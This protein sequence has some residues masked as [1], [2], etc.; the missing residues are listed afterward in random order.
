MP[1][2]TGR[3]G[4]PKPGK[5]ART[6]KTAII[7]IILACLLV[8][9]VMYW[10][11]GR[12]PGAPPGDETSGTSREAGEKGNEGN[13]PADMATHLW[14]EKAHL[15]FESDGNKDMLR[16]I[17]DKAGGE[18]SDKTGYRYQWTIN[19]KPSGGDSDS[20][21]DFKRGDIIAVRITPFEEEKTGTAKVM[22]VVVQ[23]TSP[24]VSETKELKNDG[25]NLVYQVIAKDN[26]GDKLTYTLVDAPEGAVID[27]S[28]GVINWSIKDGDKTEPKSFK[29][30][31]S[32]GNGGETVYPVNILVEKKTEKEQ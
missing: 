23:N 28:S 17:I 11:L 31:V 20:I 19:E 16:A 2:K 14:I 25:K 4:Q 32:D 12:S 1:I 8:A 21:G 13:K 5:S 10:A 29:V 24:K 15:K 18:V 27:S 7:A 9:G 22:S 26:D 30:K 3:T 6:G